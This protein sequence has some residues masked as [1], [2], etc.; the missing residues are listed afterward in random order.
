MR[1]LFLTQ[2]YPPEVGATQNRVS[3]LAERLVRAGHTV[4]VLTAMPNYPQGRVFDGYRKRLWM[5]ESSKGVRILRIWIY[6]TNRVGLVARL[7]SYC[8]YTVAAALMAIAKGGEDRKS[9]V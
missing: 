3:D 6:A 1:F 2:F 9:V 7:L 4:T 8:C 5:E